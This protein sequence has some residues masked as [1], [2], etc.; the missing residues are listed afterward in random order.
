[1]STGLL[2]IRL[3]KLA[4]LKNENVII[5]RS[6]LLHVGIKEWEQIMAFNLYIVRHGQ[7]YL[8]KYGRMQGW[9]DAPLTE[10]GIAD[11]FAAGER[12]RNVKFAHAYSSD[13]TRANN[14]AKGI[15][16]RNVASGDLKEPQKLDNFREVF[17]GIY[18]GLL[19]SEVAKQISG[20]L[21]LDET[22]ETYGELALALGMD[23]MMDAFHETDPYH[24]AENAEMFWHRFDNG[25]KY[26]FENHQDGDNILVVAHGTLIRNMAAR[27]ENEALAKD[28][29]NNG[30]IALWEVSEEE[31]KVK[32]YNDVT[33]VW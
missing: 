31:I 1:M 11:A 24:D 22:S 33:T 2:K 21:N 15:L 4:T 16:A 26:I 10:S 27:F 19:G 5:Y 32:A 25:L 18:E 20:E 14:T 3:V 29:V 12:L 8:N 28:A 13:L 9:S 30:G 17:F 7:T 6:N 23:G